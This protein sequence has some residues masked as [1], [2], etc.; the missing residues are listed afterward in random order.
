ML[1]SGTLIASKLIDSLIISVIVPIYITVKMVHNLFI[2]WNIPKFIFFGNILLINIY[3]NERNNFWDRRNEEEE[4]MFNP[5][6]FTR[7]GPA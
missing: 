1:L 6:L 7:V 2:H 4:L 3:M 5:E